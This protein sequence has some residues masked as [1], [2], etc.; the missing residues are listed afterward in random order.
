LFH[1]LVERGISRLQEQIMITLLAIFLRWFHLAYFG[2]MLPVQ[3]VRG[4]QRHHQKNVR[5]PSRI[6]HFR[7]SS[8]S[9]A[10][11]ALLSLI[12]AREERITVFPDAIPPVIAMLA[13]IA[14]YLSCV[15]FMFPRWRKAVEEQAPAVY[16]FMPIN[17]TERA[18]WIVVS[19]VAGISEEITWR[20]VQVALLTELTGSYGLA[21][22][23][24]AVSFA[25]VHYIQGLRSV[26]I[27]VLFALGFQAL[28]WVSESLYVAMAVHIA[29]DITAG[30]MYGKLGRRFG[31]TGR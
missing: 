17:A 15:A 7:Q 12:V 11:F 22:L 19:V 25:A 26:I 21:A 16:W 13:G 28:V 10:M 27:I 14:M 29:Y 23:A 5:L 9:L 31:S 18:W 20:C 8:L 1:A 24:S 6:R 30:L 2:V 4:A 3:V